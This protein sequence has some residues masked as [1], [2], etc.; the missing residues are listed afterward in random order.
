VVMVIVSVSVLVN[1]FVRAGVIVMVSVSILV[2]VLV[3]STVSAMVTVSVSVLVNVFVRAG[4]IVMVSVNTTSVTFSFIST[5]LKEVVPVLLL[6]YPA[7][8]NEVELAR[9]VPVHSNFCAPAEFV[10]HLIV[11]PATAVAAPLLNTA[12]VAT[13]M[14]FASVPV[15]DVEVVVA[16]VVAPIGEV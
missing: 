14:P 11:L 12:P 6:V 10:S 13:I 1:A 4:V 8:T 15:I 3:V 7:V 16:V 2:N 9:V 5:T